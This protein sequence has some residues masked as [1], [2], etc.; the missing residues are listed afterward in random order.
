MQ[1]YDGY[2][3]NAV[4]GYD[5]SIFQVSGDGTG[6]ITVNESYDNTNGK[7]TAGKEAGASVSIT[8]DSGNPG[9]AT[10]SPGGSDSDFLYFYNT[11]SAFY[12]DLSTN[13]GHL[14]TGSLVAQSGTFTNAALAGAY[15]LGQTALTSS[16]L[17]VGEISLAS[18]GT[19]AG[20]VS[21]AG[22]GDFSWDQS[23]GGITYSWLST[24]YG[25]LSLSSGGKSQTCAVIS[26]TGMVCMD[27]TSGSAK[28]MIL[29]Q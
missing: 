1:G 6:N 15:M 4:Q 9:R 17:S 7:T 21:T 19:A 18:N 27:N 10:F 20:N 14:E 22:E 3:N 8:F 13:G 5:S 24:T 12:L 23:Q 29:Q 28:L 26:G 11:N 16:D 2:S 25:T